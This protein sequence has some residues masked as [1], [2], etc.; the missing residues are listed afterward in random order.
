M[1]CT[2]TIYNDP[3]HKGHLCNVNNFI[4][5]HSVVGEVEKGFVM[6]FG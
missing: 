2:N 5:L 6:R 4:S 3:N 1:P